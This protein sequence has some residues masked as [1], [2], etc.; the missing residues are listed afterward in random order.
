MPSAAKKMKERSD[1][2]AAAL[3]HLSDVTERCRPRWSPVPRNSSVARK[4]HARGPSWRRLL[5]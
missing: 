2:S 5:T 4:A 1:L 3:L